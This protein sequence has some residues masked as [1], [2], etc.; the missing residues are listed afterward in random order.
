MRFSTIVIRNLLRRKLRSL[1]TILGISIG[2]GTTVAL[3]NISE[4]FRRIT[5]DS[6]V[7]RGIDLV[8]M[9]KDAVDQLSSDVDVRVLPLVKQIPGVRDVCP[10]LADL[11]AFPVRNSTVNVLMQGWE[12]GNLLFDALQAD[13]KAK[14]M[15][16]A[17]LA[18]QLQKRAG[19]SLEIFGEPFEIAG[20]YDSFSLPESAGLVMNL[21]EMQR[22]MVNEGHVTGFGV[23]LDPDHADPQAVCAAINELKFPDGRSARV[24]AQS[25]R[26]YVKDAV[27]FKASR[28]MALVTSGIAVFVG[29]IGI[30]NTMIMSVVERIREISLLR[31]IGWKRSRVTRMVVGESV[32]LSLLGSAVGV[33]AAYLLVQLLTRL[34][35]TSGVVDGH[36]TWYV[37]MFGVSMAA[38]VGLIGGIYP[39]VRAANL[40]PSHGLRN[41]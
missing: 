31:A 12:P 30:L 7:G 39:A 6:L 3:L 13:D 11:G 35:E 24:R 5:V 8:V 16:G 15:L 1:L 40:P 9:E 17:L 33:V 21:A 23:A 14:V 28:A 37:V 41:E 27:H 29:A 10:T 38:F 2:V 18:E 20:V 19:D 34:P 4:G 32:T 22:V 25:V 26:D 36:M